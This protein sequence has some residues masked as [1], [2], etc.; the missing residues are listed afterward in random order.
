MIRAIK[1]ALDY[2]FTDIQQGEK[3]DVD[4][5]KQGKHFSKSVVSELTKG[6]EKLTY[7]NDLLVQELVATVAKEM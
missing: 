7:S 5:F 1:G 4:F 3:A 6:L 2:V